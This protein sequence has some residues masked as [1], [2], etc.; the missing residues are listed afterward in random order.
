MVQLLVILILLVNTVYAFWTVFRNTRDIA[1]SWAWLLVLLVPVIGPIVYLII[2]RPI[3]GGRLRAEPVV[4]NRRRVKF[5]EKQVP[6][7]GSGPTRM[8]KRTLLRSTASLLTSDNKLQLYTDFDEFTA[9]LLHDLARAQSA[10]MIEAYS[11]EPDAVGYELRTILIARVQAGVRVDL[12]YD[13]FGSRRL[14]PHFWQPLRR[15]GGV[16]EAFGAGQFGQINPR[17]NFRNH[18]KIVVIDAHTAYTGGFN[19]GR[20]KNRPR[21]AG[22]YHLRVRGGGVWELMSIFVRDWN[23]TARTQTIATIPPRVNQ[24]AQVTS[25]SGATV[26]FMPSRPGAAISDLSLAYQRL[27]AAASDFVYIQSPYF[28]PD[29]SLLDALALAIGR[30]VDVRIMI[31]K[32]SD[33]KVM[34]RASLFYLEQ[35]CLLG[36]RVFTYQGGFLRSKAIISEGVVALGTA[37]FDPR[38]FNLNYEVTSF[39]YGEVFSHTMTDVFLDNQGQSRELNRNYFAHVPAG[40]RLRSEFARL[41]APIL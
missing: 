26:Q 41:I 16:V 6:L 32:Q 38:S 11:I 8:L 5:A 22:D 33:K 14:P 30:G 10:I 37:N 23:R 1:S 17:V 25:G 4:Y 21:L 24:D 18:R 20:Q 29:S 31:P 3:V 12:L 13:A 7:V 40:V 15:A 39:V 35:L 28:I 36:A 19:V 9:N 34:T 2:G 27:I